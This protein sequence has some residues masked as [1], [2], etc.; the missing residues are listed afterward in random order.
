MDK[1]SI[2]QKIDTVIQLLRRKKQQDK[3]VRAR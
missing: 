2:F 3:Y 1:V